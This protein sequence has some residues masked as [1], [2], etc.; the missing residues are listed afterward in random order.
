[1]KPSN[2]VLVLSTLIAVLAL[3]AAGT[4]LFW[5]GG[6]GPY[7]FTTLRGESAE[8]Y[9]FGLYRYD[10]LFTGAGNRA[11]DA[12]TLALG[13]P[14]LIIS[15][16]LYLRGSLRGGLLL[17]GTLGFFLYVYASYALGAVAYN[18][19]FLLYVALFSASLYAFVLAFA[20]VD[21][22]ALGSRFSARMP[23]R[24]PAVFMLASGLVTLVVWAGPLVAALISG[25]VPGRLDIYTTK[26]TE[27]LDLA[28]ITP[29]TLLAGALILRRAPLGYLIALSLLVL[30]AMLAPLIV[31]Q[32]VSQLWAGVP[33]TTGEVVGPMAGFLILAAVALWVL[34]AILRNIS[35]QE[36]S[37]L[38]RAK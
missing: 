35:G 21:L 26:L 1:M 3:F 27:A 10:T 30:E 17:L 22:R 9:G 28:T 12:V 31:A 6:D 4:G 33:F 5:R 23:R 20:A 36:P 14:L 2:A 7:T 18:E 37:R 11:T 34:V 38:A 15:T 19:L 29:A 16:L 32:T 13:I 25:E 24:G 8:I